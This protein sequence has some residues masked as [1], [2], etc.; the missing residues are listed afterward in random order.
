MELW[1]NVSVCSKTGILR[2]V[3][4]ADWDLPVHIGC[5]VTSYL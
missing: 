3:N 2:K 4:D 1:K 5:T